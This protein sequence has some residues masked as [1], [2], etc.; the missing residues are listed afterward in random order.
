MEI[1]HLIALHILTIPFLQEFESIGREQKK[2]LRI[3]QV[4]KLAHF[5]R[6]KWAWGYALLLSL[7]LALV[8]APTS[9]PHP[10]N[11]VALAT[12]LI[13]QALLWGYSTYKIISKRARGA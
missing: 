12:S 9:R 10:V 4:L 8:F 1:G 11:L 6:Q 5:R 13:A 2:I 3:A 7:V